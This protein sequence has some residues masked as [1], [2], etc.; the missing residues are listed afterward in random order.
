MRNTKTVLILLTIFFVTAT[1]ATFTTTGSHSQTTQSQQKQSDEIP[2]VDIN[3]PEPSDLMEKELR[4]RRGQKY[5]TG[6]ALEEGTDSES[7]IL[8]LPLSHSPARQAFP[9]LE[10]DAIVI[11]TVTD[12]RAFLSSD[13][14]YV[15]SEFTVQ[16]E[17]TLK[18]TA[19]PELKPN[20]T[21]TTE[22]AGGAVRFA[23][24]RVRRL[25]NAG[26][27]L[28]AKKARYLLFLKWSESGK[29]FLIVT[30]YKLQGGKVT[31]LDDAD[32]KEDAV[33]YKNFKPYRNMKESR[34]LRIVRDKIENQSLEAGNK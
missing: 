18:N 22:R 1:I 29:D 4:N 16:I 23:S 2:T 7:E 15:Y 13:K 28:P 9:V 11:G 21:I 19:S 25:G 12:S 3:A 17:Q 33:T 26:E 14:S 5:N 30:G 32:E 10:S 24:G 20:A 31:P 6:A 8:E 27:G 34:F